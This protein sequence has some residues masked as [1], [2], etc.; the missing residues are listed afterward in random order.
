MKQYYTLKIQGKNEHKSKK[1]KEFKKREKINQTQMI[2]FDFISVPY[3]IVLTKK[4][5][6]SFQLKRIVSQ[7]FIFCLNFYKVFL[8]RFPPF[9]LACNLCELVP[10]T[11]AVLL[12]GLPNAWPPP[13]SNIDAAINTTVLTPKKLHD[14]I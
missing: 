10:D 3:N 9:K 12:E 14:L 11:V 4:H 1:K 13:I 5:I 6:S 7:H 8:K 2:S